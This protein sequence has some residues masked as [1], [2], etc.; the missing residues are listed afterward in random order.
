M[1]KVDFVNRLCRLSLR[2]NQQG[3]KSNLLLK[4]LNKYLQA[5]Q[6]YHQQQSNY[7]AGDETGN[8]GPNGAAIF[9]VNLI[10]LLSFQLV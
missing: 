9:F 2:L 4:S 8:Q 3:F 5:P 10:L 1:S 7:T 6:G